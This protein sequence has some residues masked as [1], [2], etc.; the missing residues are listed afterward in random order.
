MRRMLYGILA[1]VILLTGCKSGTKKTDTIAAPVHNVPSAVYPEP[2]TVNNPASQTS[3]PYPGPQG[4]GIQSNVPSG[5]VYPAPGSS[6]GQIPTTNAY[7]PASGDEKLTRGQATVSIKDSKITT[8]TTPPVQVILNL[9][10]TLPDSC[11]KLRVNPA[12]ADAENKIQVEV[13]SV[14][15]PNQTCT[16]AIQEFTAVIIPLG[17]FPTGHYSVYIN[18]ELLGE[19]DA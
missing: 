15:D 12:P 6:S 2:R 4:A 14:A 1:C 3:Q 9:T 18:G 10:G 17:S 8:L 16:Q 11:A 7:A 5:S 13:Y 19:F